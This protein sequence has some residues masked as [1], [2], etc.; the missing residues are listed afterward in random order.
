MLIEHNW[1]AWR[2]T[3][4]SAN[5]VT[6]NPTW[7]GLWLHQGFHIEVLVTN[8]LNCGMV[9]FELQHLSVADGI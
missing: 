1:S 4:S 7:N 5:L 6:T 3:C 8:H 9:C 2:K